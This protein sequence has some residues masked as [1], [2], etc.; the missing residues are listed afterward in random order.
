MPVNRPRPQSRVWN[1]PNALTLLRIALI[2]PFLY[3]MQAELTDP[4]S[5]GNV[6]SFWIFIAATVTDWVD[7]VIAR[8]LNLVTPLGKLLDPLADKLLVAAALVMLSVYH[9]VYGHTSIVVGV[10]AWVAVFIIARELAVTGLRGMAGAEGIVIHAS[11][12]GKWK[13]VLQFVAL[14]GLILQGTRPES[15]VVDLG[16]LRLDLGLLSYW[17]LW[18]AVALTAWSGLAYFREFLRKLV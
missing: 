17:A 11:A 1:L 7:G 15:V 4:S 12:G 5:S 10:P 2:F 8:H 18:V 6:W 16:A 14:G 3:F 9:G 13:T